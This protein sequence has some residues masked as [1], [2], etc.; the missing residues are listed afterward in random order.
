M[1][2]NRN[3]ESDEYYFKEGCHILELLNSN[4]D[5]DCSIARARLE[6]GKETQLHRLEN[7]V[8]RYVILQ[9]DGEVT[10]ADDVQA[11]SVNDIVF[12]AENMPQKIRN[13]GSQD[14]IFLAICTPRFEEKNY[15]VCE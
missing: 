9:G 10:V 11:V 12:I 6:A 15:R 3:T 2:V 1:M 14:L 4:D 13:T 5:P 7:T 8:E